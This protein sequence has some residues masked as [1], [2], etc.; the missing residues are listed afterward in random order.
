MLAIIVD[1]ARLISM[2]SFIYQK[3][4]I[5]FLHFLLM[6][7]LVLYSG[8]LNGTEY[9]EKALVST[10]EA[11][12]DLILSQLTSLVI[13]KD[14][15]AFALDVKGCFVV[16]FTS[17]L[18]YITH[19]GRSGK[20]PGD[21]GTTYVPNEDRLSVD[22]NGDI[23]IND[24]NPNRLVIY[25]NSGKYKQDINIQVLYQKYFPFIENLKVIC[26]GYFTGKMYNNDNTIDAVIFKIEPPEIKLKVP[27]KEERIHVNIG[28]VHVVGIK[29]SYYGDNF[30][31]SISRDRIGFADSQRYHFG[32]YTKE[33]QKIFEVEESKRTM[34]S[35]SDEEME[36]ISGDFPELKARNHVLLKK[37]LDQ[38]KNRK[39]VI[40]TI[41]LTEDHIFVFCV[42][43]DITKKDIYPVVIYNSKG[44]IV[45][46][47]FF[48]K[49][50]ITIWKDYAY[51]IESDKNDEP[52][53]LKYQLKGL[54]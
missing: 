36:K 30:S 4:R 47:V 46:S 49:I 51:Y 12:K 42:S 44:N 3:K 31:I 45:S 15:N 21:F 24:Y 41:K 7:F 38:L 54:N 33:G 52:I 22:A 14:G 16:K 32:V 8:F 27:I 26:N 25:D 50:P 48:R 23:Y 40:S 2:K 17:D 9:F 29:E 34:G 20:G 13:D 10:S 6:I 1:I 19:F 37:L 28:D 18:K 39:N 35:F 53:I 5:S 43:D 11:P